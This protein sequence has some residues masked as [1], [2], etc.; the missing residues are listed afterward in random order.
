AWLHP[1]GPRRCR[2]PHLRHQIVV[3]VTAFSRPLVRARC[4]PKQP[5][6]SRVMAFAFRRARLFQRSL[7]VSL[8]V[9]AAVIAG[10][11]ADSWAASERLDLAGDVTPVAATATP[12]LVGAKAR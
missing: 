4:N 9:A 6:W 10:L 11:A 1:A 8:I 7:R 5:S 3:A 2:R 12:R